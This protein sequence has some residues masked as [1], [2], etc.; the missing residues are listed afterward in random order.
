[1][2]KG[3]M[4]IVCLG[5]FLGM[6]AMS[7]C[8]GEKGQI[9]RGGDPG[10]RGIPGT[11][12]D[13]DRPQDRYFGVGVVN[14]NLRAV[15]GDKSVFLTFDSTAR[16]SRDTVVAARVY[17]PPL[18]NGIDGEEVEWGEQKSRIRTSL[19]NTNSGLTDPE[20]SEIV[21]RVAWDEYYIY[22]YFQWK[23]RKV[24]I[25]TE[26][27]DSTIY[28]VT[29]SD[30]PNELVMDAH[31]KIIE[32]IDSTVT[33]Y[34]TTLFQW[35]RVP[36][37]AVDTLFC[38][39]DPLLQQIVCVVDTA[40]GDTTLIWFDSKKG[41]D[42]LAVFWGDTEVENWSDLA[43]REFFDMSGAGGP[44]PSGLFV[45]AWL[46]GAGT[47]NPVS[48]ADDWSLTSRGEAP[49]VGAASFILNHS[50]PD[51][52]PRY[53]YYR[54]PNYKSQLTLQRE[55]YPLWYF[56][57]VGF[58]P[59]GWDLNRPVY[60][61]GIVSTIPSGSRADIYA[62]ATFDDSGGGIWTLEIRRAR[63]TNTGDDV[64]F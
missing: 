20:I 38:Y 22:T 12:P 5:L 62:R 52:V 14:E 19:L 15:S 55:I 3:I 42:K 23:E 8:E 58:S 29:T 31:S 49:D 32:S 47:S 10:D 39:F 21:C 1:M 56:D 54:D 59:A 16:A 60:L 11:D 26:T 64:V 36:V 35:V 40:F 18:I 63:K 17:N 4:Y 9:G 45:D 6:F 24:S 37:L 2:R 30:S 27:G 33:P 28:E 34:D 50:L 48:A 13:L 46:W 53:Q 41:E 44:L 57:A 25:R 43:F 51:S 61:P 7:G